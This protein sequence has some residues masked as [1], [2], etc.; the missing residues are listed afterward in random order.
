MFLPRKVGRAA[1]RPGASKHIAPPAPP[2]DARVP[3]GG[4][5]L[6]LWHDEDEQ[7]VPAPQAGEADGETAGESSAAGEGPVPA[8]Q[9]RRAGKELVAELEA[10]CPRSV[11]YVDLG[12][13]TRAHEGR[14]RRQL[15][16]RTPTASSASALLSALQRR[17]ADSASTLHDASILSGSAEV[18]YWAALPERVRNA[19]RKTAA[20]E[21][22]LVALRRTRRRD[23]VQRRRERRKVAGRR[24]APA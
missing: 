13:E 5:L 12:A 16:V 3:A 22:S 7:V 17:P 8:A 1:A 11:A 20:Q 9:H 23:K 19:A 6:Q 10:L 21:A 18:A 2:L 14:R 4:L 24:A 15:I